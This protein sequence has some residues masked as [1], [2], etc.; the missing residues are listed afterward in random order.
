M[1]ANLVSQYLNDS[2]LKNAH[3]ALCTGVFGTYEVG[4]MERDYLAVLD[5]KLGI[6]DEDMSKT[7]WNL[8]ESAELTKRHKARLSQHRPMRRA[9]EPKPRE[10]AKEATLV[11]YAAGR[12]A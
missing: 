5:F 8:E 9:R 10:R 3:W 4:C 7:V 6:T 1:T 12:L 2:T 11:K